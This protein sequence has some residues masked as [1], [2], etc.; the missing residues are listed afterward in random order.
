MQLN[1]LAIKNMYLL[2]K[3]DDLFNQFYGVKVF[4]KVDLRYEYYQ[5]KVK[6]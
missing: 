2:P 4:S 5:L 6:E 3:I 1:K